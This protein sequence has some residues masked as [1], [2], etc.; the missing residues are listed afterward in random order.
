M[1]MISWISEV[2][3]K[4]ALAVGIALITLCGSNMAAWGSFKFV[5]A[6]QQ[7]LDYGD[8]ISHFEGEKQLKVA[9]W[10]DLTQDLGTQTIFSMIDS[11]SDNGIKCFYNNNRF[12]F[13][14]ENGVGGSVQVSTNA[15]TGDPDTGWAHVAFQMDM[16]LS[17]TQMRAWV[18]GVLQDD[19]V[20]SS[21]TF[22]A[23][24]VFHPDDSDQF[25]IG[26][27]R[28]TGLGAA[29]LNGHV[30]DLFIGTR[31][32]SSGEVLAFGDPSEDPLTAEPASEWVVA[33]SA[34]QLFYALLRNDDDADVGPDPPGD[35]V[36]PT[37]ENAPPKSMG[38]PLD[39]SGIDTR[40][41]V[42][43]I[44][45]TQ[46]LADP[47]AVGDPELLKMVGD[48]ISDH[49]DSLNL[50]AVIHVGDF[51]NNSRQMPETDR[52][53]DFVDRFIGDVIP[54]PIPFAMTMGNHDADSGAGNPTERG[55][56]NMGE[57]EA[58]PM[59]LVNTKPWYLDEMVTFVSGEDD[60]E[61]LYLYEFNLGATELELGICVPVAPTIEM[62]EWVVDKAAEY[63]DRRVWLSTHVHTVGL[64]YDGG[65]HDNYFNEIPPPL[66]SD[67]I[68]CRY[69]SKIPNLAFVL[70]G[71]YSS[72]IIRRISD[73]GC[74]GCDGNP[75]ESL[76]VNNQTGDDGG[77]G[78]MAILT[79]NGGTVEVEAYRPAI[80]EFDSSPFNTFDFP[81][82]G[83]PDGS[84]PCP[85]DFNG[86]GTVNS[87]DRTLLTDCI[88]DP[89]P[90]CANCANPHLPSSPYGACCFDLNE[91]CVV[92][93]DDLT[94]LQGLQ[95]DCPP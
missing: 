47:G 93:S 31:L 52:A 70:S 77:L 57:D 7:S 71:H 28:A 69:Y 91:D 33:F 9:F 56:T 65:Q 41:R 12:S 35:A 48:F 64:I 61:Y 62:L 11:T 88:D 78:F 76:R 8:L 44:G 2:A 17:Q 80:N 30:H 42:L 24:L 59:T 38:P 66:N 75:V 16:R 86:D 46:N 87:A 14:A 60:G 53:R 94:I 39:Y 89:D 27:L 54:I 50:A 68:W 29:Y 21:V 82:P 92:D 73:S 90:D 45:D 36:T 40:L 23:G 4:R 58:L 5:S 15:G 51:V 19:I 18:N 34:R 72:S 37:D 84:T 55:Y 32:W 3:T 63:P 26:R 83:P 22:P 1:N 6:D 95:G 10:V 85:G 67:Q 81:L 43:V 74:D 49:R 25:Y 13:F 20:D 79:I